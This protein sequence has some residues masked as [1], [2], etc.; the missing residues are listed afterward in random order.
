MMIRVPSYSFALLG[1][2][3]AAFSASAP[4][5]ATELAPLPAGC[6]LAGKRFD[7][8][9]AA[10]APKAVFPPTQLQVRVPVDPVVL[11][12]GA[13]RYLVYELHLQNFG[14]LALHLAAIEV[15]GSHGAALKPVAQ[16][17]PGDLTPILQRVGFDSAEDGAIQPGGTVVAFLCIALGRNVQVPDQLR[18]R[19]VLADADIEGPALAINGA[20]L[21]VLGR[22]LVGPDWNPRNGPHAGSHHRTGLFVADGLATISRRYAIDWRK[23]RQGASFSGDPRDLRSYFSYGEKVL[24]VADGT[25]VVANDGMPDNIPKTDAGFELAVPL[26][27]ETIVGNAV[28]IDMGGGH[29]ASYSHLQQ[30]SVQVRAGERVRRGQLIGRVGNSGDARWPHLHFQVSGKPNPMSGEGEAFVIDSYRQKSA[31][32]KWE[33]RT[34]EFPWGDSEVIDFGPDASAR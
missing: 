29:L 22:P 19:V 34:G 33:T 16:Y 6:Q 1:L 18:H 8:A 9:S 3:A 24:A 28:V 26:T 23:S 31:D 11:P 17:G 15:S 21:P 20:P 14:G 2:L 32:G 12:S 27:M 5:A 25:V 7:L 30:A 13:F 4:A 10:R